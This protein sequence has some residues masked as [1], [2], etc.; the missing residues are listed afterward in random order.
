[1]A[2]I[3]KETEADSSGKRK[4]VIKRLF[5]E[6]GQLPVMEVPDVP[7]IPRE[8]E[9]AQPVPGAGTQVQP[10]TDDQTGQILV[11]GP[12]GQSNVVLPLTADEIRAGLTYKVVDSFRW[13]AEWCLRLVKMMGKVIKKKK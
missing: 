9:Q 5:G 2:T 12:G 6:K 10:V 4:E 3:D 8:I 11:S 1:V 13:L 7:E